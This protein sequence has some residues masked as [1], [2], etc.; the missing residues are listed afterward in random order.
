MP[1]AVLMKWSRRVIL[2][3]C[4][5]FY[6]ILPARGVAVGGDDPLQ[7][8]RD[9]PYVFN[10]SKTIQQLIGQAAEEKGTFDLAAYLRWTR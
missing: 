7:T 9:S 5:L 1:H 6:F 3:V 2:F 10:N 4:P 8:L